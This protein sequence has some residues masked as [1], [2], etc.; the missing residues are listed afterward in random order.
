M[1]LRPSDAPRRPGARRDFLKLSAASALTL[2]CVPARLFAAPEEDAPKITAR[3]LVMSDV[4]FK[5]REKE[6]ERFRSAV[7]FMYEHCDAHKTYRRFDALLVVGD[8]SNHG[9]VEEI[10]LFK[11]TIDEEIHGETQTLLCMGNH[12]FN[13]GSRSLWREV[14]GV[15]PNARYDVNGYR[16]IALSPEKG[17]CANGDY[18]YALDWLKAELDDA[19][20]ADP[21]KPVFLFQHY[22]VSQTVFGS[23][24]RNDWGLD[25]LFDLLQKYPRVVDFSGHTHYSLKNPGIVWQGNFTAF[26]TSMLSYF[27]QGADGGRYPEAPDDSENVAEC[28]VMEILEDNSV[29][30]FPYDVEHNAFYGFSYVVYPGKTESYG[31]TDARYFNTSRPEFG[32][33]AKAETHEVSDS[34]V[35][36]R[37]TQA[38]CPDVVF[39]YRLDVRRQTAD[40]E[41]E[42]E[43]PRYLSSR[44]YANPVPEVLD[45]YL[46]GLAANTTY[47][48]TITALSAFEMESPDKLELEFTTTEDL[49][50]TGNHN[51]PAPDPNYID[52][53]VVG[54]AVVNLP[55]NNFPEQKTPILVGSPRVVKDPEL[56]EEVMTFNG[57]D[58]CAAVKCSENEY[59]RLGKLSLR[60]YFRPDMTRTTGSASILSN[61]EGKGAALFF[62][63]A[64]KELSFWA[65]VGG[66]YV[67][68][69]SAAPDDRWTDVVGVYDGNELRLY[70]DGTEVDRVRAEGAVEHPSNPDVRFFGVGGEIETKNS[71]HY[72]F[73]GRVARA[74]V[75]SWPLTAAQVKNLHEAR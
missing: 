41:W 31:F 60:A 35:R 48:L 5:G 14:F 59:Q 4:H 56:G 46:R 37:F 3:C 57:A 27:C 55:V 32:H 63:Y 20:A 44:Y 12:E 39:G 18:L 29:E 75:Y 8:M 11:K 17:S 13:G 21:E 74:S 61:T 53:R 54:G 30:M 50:D 28:Y 52:V 34:W 72:H 10:G 45:E 42:V 6:V 9:I 47:R 23:R 1:T 49:L 69:K 66:K 16:F 43:A 64:K 7:R 22:P 38:F 19:M 26:G 71:W 25:D 15:E 2:A 40:G 58:S 36:L 65:Y 70:V 67:V 68:A 24:G 33:D 51:D 73:A 62:D